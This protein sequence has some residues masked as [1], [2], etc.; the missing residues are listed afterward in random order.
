MSDETLVPIVCP[1]CETETEVALDGL[2][3]TLDRH[4]EQF[5]DGQEEARVDP[6]LSDHL[7]DLV[8]ED[9]GLLGDAG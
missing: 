7:A 2:A 4:N 8:V 9:M 1:A 3:E 5:H 6:E